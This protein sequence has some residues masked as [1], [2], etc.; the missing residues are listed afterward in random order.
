MR[1]GAV[2]CLFVLFF[3]PLP[4]RGEQPIDVLRRT[5]NVGIAVLKDPEYKHAAKKAE[6]EKVLCD[7]AWQAFDFREFSR[8]VLSSH[9]QSFSHEQRKEF[10]DVFAEFLCKYYIPKLQEKYNDEKVVYFDQKFITSSRASVRVDV[11][12]KGTEVPVEVRMLKRNSTW[13][14]YDIVILGVS[15]IKNYRAQFQ[16]LLRNKKPSEVIER[17]KDRIQEED[18]KKLVGKRSSSQTY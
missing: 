13:K 6:Q 17:I 2:I 10:I 15:G 4:V 3:M 7:V 8:R 14:V 1:K 12:W 18:G 5:V 16:A 11:L 9:W